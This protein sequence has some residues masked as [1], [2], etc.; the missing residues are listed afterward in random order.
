MILG[1]VHIVVFVLLYDLGNGIPNSPRLLVGP[2]SV[3]AVLHPHRV[4]KG[5]SE[6]ICE[7]CTHKS[8]TRKQYISSTFPWRI[9]RSQ[10]IYAQRLVPYLQQNRAGCS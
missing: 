3:V 4:V 1:R 2:L 6:L 5:F 9:E 8:Y 7:I 10:V